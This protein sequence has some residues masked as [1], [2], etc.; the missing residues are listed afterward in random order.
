MRLGTI[1]D[2][3][4]LCNQFGCPVENPVAV[5]VEEALPHPDW[6]IYRQTTVSYP[7]YQT[8]ALFSIVTIM[9]QQ[10][11]NMSHERQN[12]LLNVANSTFCKVEPTLDNEIKI[13]VTNPNRL[14]N[15]AVVKPSYPIGSR[16]LYKKR[17][18]EREPEFYGY[19]IIEAVSADDDGLQ[20]AIDGVA[21]FAHSSIVGML[22][23]ATEE[24]VAWVLAYACEGDEDEED[25]FGGTNDGTQQGC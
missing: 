24:S 14:A 11:A 5:P 23:P 1:K 9:A 12:R 15:R 3:L 8:T 10:T 22:E 20:Y 18:F 13:W 2:F 25:D 6:S 7:P 19:G 17:H 16:V 4:D 21:W